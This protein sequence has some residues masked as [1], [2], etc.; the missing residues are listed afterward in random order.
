MGWDLFFGG[1]CFVGGCILGYRFALEPDR[2]IHLYRDHIRVRWRMLCS[3]KGGRPKINSELIALIRRMSRENP[4]WGAPHIHGE[5][6]MLGYRIAQS[7]VSK[8][9]IPRRGRP[10]QSWKTLLHNHKDA[11]AAIDM[12]VVT[13]RGLSQL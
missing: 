6:R 4:L 8:Y 10:K 9:M 11:I 2:L 5:L 7:T 13:T 12:L 3:R 1:G